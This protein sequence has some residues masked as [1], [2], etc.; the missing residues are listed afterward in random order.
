MPTVDSKFPGHQ[1]IKS[2]IELSVIQWGKCSIKYGMERSIVTIHMGLYWWEKYGI[3]RWEKSAL[4]KSALYR[5]RDMG[6]SVEKGT[7]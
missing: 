4:S 3:A 1:C 7:I 2:V 6:C 5:E